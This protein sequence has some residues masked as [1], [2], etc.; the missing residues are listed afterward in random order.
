MICSAV[1]A[2]GVMNFS[3][4]LRSSRVTSPLKAD[5]RAHFR[6]LDNGRGTSLSG[7]RSEYLSALARRFE[8]AVAAS[9]MKV[10]ITL[11]LCFSMA[12]SPSGTT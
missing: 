8:N 3:L 5:L 7:C 2:N 1:S 11:A 9:A 10:L 6:S 4:S 12:S